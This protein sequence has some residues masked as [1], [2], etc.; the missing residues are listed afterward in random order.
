MDARGGS[1]LPTNTRET[2]EVSETAAN[3]EV[4]PVGRRKCPRIAV[5]VM[6]LAFGSA[7][8]LPSATAEDSGTVLRPSSPLGGMVVH[9]GEIDPDLAPRGGSMADENRRAV[10]R[11]ARLIHSVPTQY[12]DEF[13]GTGIVGEVMISLMVDRM[14]RASHVK[15]ENTPDKAFADAAL[16]SLAYWEFLPALKAGRK[17]N[18]K[19]KLSL[20]V[21]E[22]VGESS[23]F[24]F[25]GGRISLEG[26]RYAGEIDRPVQRM[27]G[28]RAPYPY[29]R[30]VAEQGGEVL[31]EVSVD[32]DGVPYDFEI[33]ESTH[34]DFSLATEAALGQW[35][36]S[37]ALKEGKPV[38][39]RLRYRVSF[40]PDD[41]DDELLELAQQLDKGDFSGIVAAND[42]DVQPKVTHPVTPSLPT[43]REHEKKRRRVKLGL[44]VSET[45]AVLIPRIE[46]APNPLLGYAAMTAVNY[47]RFSPAQK[48]RVPVRVNVTIPITF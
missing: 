4:V 34:R 7:F 17:T 9:E 6:V 5:K 20:L 19:L 41:Y 22:E 28:L 15:V 32:D 47:W 23:Y 40:Q 8:V 42:L 30:L 2:T 18:A 46:S 1:G 43:D 12:P 11:P 37:P 39:A 25:A 35:R 38:I 48:D 29:D 26:T 16:D 36:Y 10:D 45:G 21:A 33:I 13:E 31:V 14:G 3:L 44:V 24:D 27:Y